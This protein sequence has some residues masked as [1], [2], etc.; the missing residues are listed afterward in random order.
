M[1]D[2]VEVFKGEG[3]ILPGYFWRLVSANGQTLGVSESY[4]TKWSAKRTARKQA[5]RLHLELVDTTA[6]PYRKFP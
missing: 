4:T 6:K 5:E 3:R 2:H 1:S